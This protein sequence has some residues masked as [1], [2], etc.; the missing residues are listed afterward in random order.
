MA[1]TLGRTGLESLLKRTVKLV[2]MVKSQVR[3]PKGMRE[4]CLPLADYSIVYIMDSAT[5]H[6]LMVQGWGSWMTDQLSYLTGP[7]PSL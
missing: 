7:D 3:K 6:T 4:L 1:A 5:K 2:L